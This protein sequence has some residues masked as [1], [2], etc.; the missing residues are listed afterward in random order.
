[1]S[2]N[3]LVNVRNFE[4]SSGTSENTCGDMHTSGKPQSFLYFFDRYITYMFQGTW[5]NISKAFACKTP[6][7]E[8]EKKNYVLCDY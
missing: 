7:A 5:H 4:A 8:K 3:V 2:N 6:Y 1:M